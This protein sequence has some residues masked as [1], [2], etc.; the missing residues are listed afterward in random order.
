V[1]IDKTLAVTHH[2]GIFGATG[3]G[4]S[5][6]ARNLIRQIINSGT[7]V[8]CVDFTNQYFD[9]FTDIKPINLLNRAEEEAAFIA[10]KLISEEMDEYPNK[11]DREKIKINSDVIDNLLYIN[12][13]KFLTTNDKMCI[14]SLPDV[15]NSAGIIEYTKRFFKVA[16]EIAKKEKNFGNRVC[17]VI[18]EAHTVIPE[19]TFYGIDDKI[20]KPLVNTIS[21][22][23]LQGRK[24]DIGFIIIAQ[25]TA[26]VSKTVITQCNSIIAFKQFDNTSKDFLS[27]YIGKEFANT[28][29]NLKIKQAIASGKAFKSDIPLLFEVPEITEQ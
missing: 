22:I 3:S 4:K 17:I 29:S 12:L 16:F 7:K 6:F 25:R 20:S 26:N 10:I 13:K 18:E 11:R 27:N 9:R 19:F 21:Q 2:L 24:Y 23:A 8:I 1:I 15:S 28:L 5:V 14:L